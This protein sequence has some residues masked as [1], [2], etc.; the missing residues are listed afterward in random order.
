MTPLV[1][2]HDETKAQARFEVATAPVP[3]DPVAL[4]WRLVAMPTE[5]ARPALMG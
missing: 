4:G 2:A 5:L 3:P 1:T